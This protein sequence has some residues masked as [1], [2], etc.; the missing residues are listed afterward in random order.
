MIRQVK[1]HR[2]KT[3]TYNRMFYKGK[4]CCVDCFNKLVDA[5]PKYCYL[6]KGVKQ[7]ARVR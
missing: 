1:C 3:K 4:A 6:F 5:D 7:E 2:C